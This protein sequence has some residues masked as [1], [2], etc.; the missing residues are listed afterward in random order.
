MAAMICFY[1]QPL[2]RLSGLLDKPD[3]V[4]KLHKCETP[5]IGGIALLVPSLLISIPFLSSMHQVDQP[6]M[7][8]AIAATAIALAIGVLDDI[9]SL[10][11]KLRLVAFAAIVSTVFV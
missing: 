4:L 10:S 8:I 1:A 5:L 11:P 6:F 3:G 9:Y 2:G 7:A